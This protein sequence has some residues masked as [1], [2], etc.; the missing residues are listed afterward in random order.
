MNSLKVLKGGILTLIQDMGRF[1]FSHLGV[2]QA[3][4][5]DEYSALWANKLLNNEQNSALLE[6]LFG[7]VEFQANADTN[8]SIT[9]AKVPLFINGIEKPTWRSYFIKTGDII[10]LGKIQSG[11]RVYLAIKGGF[12]VQKELK[13]ASSSIKEGFGEKKIKTNSILYFSPSQKLNTQ[14]VQ[15]KLIPN[16]NEALSLRVVLA[17]QHEQFDKKEL[18][19]FFSSSFQ[20]SP[21]FNRMAC[22]LK[23]ESIKCN[24][25][26]IISEGISFGAI[27]I[28]KDGQAIILLKER[29]TIGG[30]PKIGSVL[31]IDC[32]KLAQAKIGTFIN[33]EPI[34][35]DE[36]QRKMKKFYSIFH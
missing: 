33:F 24:I 23:G 19:K 14:K 16:Y 35:I 36:A 3:G 34:E 8:I 4:H 1:G 21:D 26:G 27:Q 31:A 6:I 22:K 2:S 5:L 32:F 17:Y 25:S 7:D 20:V 11:T 13:S 28:P 15:D 9:G 29:Q 10:K 12:V 30:Y 18:D